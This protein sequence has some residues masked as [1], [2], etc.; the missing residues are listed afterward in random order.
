MPNRRCRSRRPAALLARP[1]SGEEPRAGAKESRPRPAKCRADHARAPPRGRRGCSAAASHERYACDRH[2][3]L[4][5]NCRRT[6]VTL[7]ERAA[8]STTR[9]EPPS[10][11][12]WSSLDRS[13][14]LIEV[15]VVDAQALRDDRSRPARVCA[16][17]PDRWDGTRRE[18]NLRGRRPLRVGESRRARPASS[19]APW[20]NV[21]G[22]EEVHGHLR[23]AFDEWPLAYSSRPG[24]RQC[25]ILRHRAETQRETSDRRPEGRTPEAE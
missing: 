14:D 19:L 23:E 8:A 6:C 12:R 1:V 18:V 17:T 10:Y 15:D 3:L 24:P 4:S 2:V 20:S 25:S 21:G 7:R 5:K 11:P 22:V 9:A 16:I 13:V